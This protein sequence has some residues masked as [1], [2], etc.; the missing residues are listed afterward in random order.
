MARGP[1]WQSIYGYLGYYVHLRTIPGWQGDPHGKVSS[2]TWDTMPVP[3][4]SQDGKA[5]GTPMTKYLRIPGILCPSRDHPRMARPMG[6]PRQSICGY[7]GY[8]AHP[9]IIPGWQGPWDP[10]DKVPGILCP[11]RDHPR[12][13]MPWVRMWVAIPNT[14]SQYPCLC[15]NQGYWS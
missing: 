5:H 4:P 11:S 14:W 13:A 6:P 8:Y 3:G 15:T 9:G 2:D 7:L 12:M 1:P 10:H